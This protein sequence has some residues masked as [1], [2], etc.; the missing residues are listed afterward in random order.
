[1]RIFRQK[2]APESLNYVSTRDIARLCD[3]SE[4]TARHW[5]RHGAPPVILRRADKDK[6]KAAG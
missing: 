4:R 1:M 3:V 6:K 2:I 5:K